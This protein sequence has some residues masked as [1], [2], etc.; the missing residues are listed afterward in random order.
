MVFA[1]STAQQTSKSSKST[2]APKRKLA[3][4]SKFRI[5]NKFASNLFTQNKQAGSPDLTAEDAQKYFEKIYADENRSYTYTPLSEMTRPA[6]PTKLFNTRCPSLPELQ[7][8]V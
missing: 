5:L 8:S 4:K 3:A 6:I 2:E 7:K 1:P